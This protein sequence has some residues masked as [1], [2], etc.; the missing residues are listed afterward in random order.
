MEGAVT[1]SEKLTFAKV[2]HIIALQ[3]GKEIGETQSAL[4]F[5]FKNFIKYVVH[6]IYVKNQSYMLKKQLQTANSYEEWREYALELDKLNGLHKWK[7]DPRSDYYDYKNTKY[8]LLFLKELRTQ[9]LTQGLL[10]TLRS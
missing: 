8:L 5:F 7:A 6:Y 4:Y 3:I 1:N 10:H 2:I 9:K